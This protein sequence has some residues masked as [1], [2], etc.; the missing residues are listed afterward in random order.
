[1]PSR[2]DI[3]NEGQKRVRDL[4]LGPGL[5]APRGPYIYL[6]SGRL[7]PIL[8]KQFAVD[9]LLQTGDGVL[10]IEEKIVRWTGSAYS[11]IT[12]ETVSNSTPG[13]EKP[14]WMKYGQA[15][16]L[17]WVMCQEDGT[18][19]W[20]SMDFAKLQAAF[21]PV[22]EAFPQTATTLANGSVCSVVSLDWVKK[23]LGKNMTGPHPIFPTP[24]GV[25]AVKAYN[26]T[27]Y[28]QAAAE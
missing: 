20:Y 4:V 12:L 22:H 15:D 7:A 11:S 26:K 17:I 19:L 27:H 6:D 28:K 10:C 13:D 5:Y 18:V 14:G 3:D 9:T 8:Q 24:E 21:W 25:D 2:F 16:R 23:V 1:M